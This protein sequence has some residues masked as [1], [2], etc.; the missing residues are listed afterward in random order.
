MVTDEER[1]KQS[2]E[3]LSR[4]TG[5]R[6]TLEPD[7]SSDAAEQIKRIKQIT[8][9]WRDKNS[10]SAFMSRLL[11][12][13]LNGPEIVSEAER[14]H[15]VPAAR[16]HLYVIEE[17]SESSDAAYRVLRQM[18]ASTNDM[19]VRLGGKKLALIRQMAGAGRGEDAVDTARMIVDMLNTEAMVRVRVAFAEP[20]ETLEEL[21]AAYQDAVTALTIGRIFYSN[22]MVI[23]FS[24]L[25]IGR[26][27]NE[28]PVKVCRRFLKE[29][30]GDRIPDDFD[31]ETQSTIDTFLCNNLNISET[32]RQLY[33]HRNTLVYRLEKLHQ[34]TGLDIRL[35][36]DAMTFKIASMVNGYLKSRESDE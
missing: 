20:A 6:L 3:E 19:I 26:L 15:I 12:G 31:E 2:I 28:L 27:I 29:V 17:D 4:L 9:A 36:E 24:R 8:S 1:L 34:L 32:A 5:L 22:E 35:F 11:R 18:F 30:Y 23:D 33:L 25:G 21:P 14:F 10:R 16:R 13:E 7:E